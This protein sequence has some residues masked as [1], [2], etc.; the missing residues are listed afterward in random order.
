MNIAKFL[1]TAFLQSTSR[2]SRLEMSFKKAVRKSF[3]NFTGKHSCW[4]LFLIS[5]QD[6][7]LQLYFKKAP[8]QVFFFEVCKIFRNTLFN[9]R[10]PVTA[11]ALPVTAS[12]FFFQKVIN[13]YCYLATL[14]WRTNNILDTSFDV[15]KV[16]LV[17]L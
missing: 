3:Q 6:E 5:L 13:S 1:R 17:C 8:A 10:P 4:S 9:G 12:V 2:S 11:F 16:E 14:L 15:Q 7:G